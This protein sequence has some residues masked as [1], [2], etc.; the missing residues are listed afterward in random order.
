M[1]FFLGLDEIVAE[2]L[3]SPSLFVEWKKLGNDAFNNFFDVLTVVCGSKNK[4]AKESNIE[5]KWKLKL[6]ATVADQN[7]TYPVD[8]NLLNTAR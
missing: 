1:Q 6:D 7:I 8:L 3:F 4:C 2:P 5:N